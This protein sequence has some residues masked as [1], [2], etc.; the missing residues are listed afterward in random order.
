MTWQ[1]NALLLRINNPRALLGLFLGSTVKK[2]FNL[3]LSLER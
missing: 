2:P 3:F 1:A